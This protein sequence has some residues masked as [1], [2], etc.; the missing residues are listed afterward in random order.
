MALL[1]LF[2]PENDLALA[3]NI[4][5]YTP[6]RA[7]QRLSQAGA[8]LP[9][10][11]GSEGD[12]LLC[13]GVPARWYD[14]VCEAFGLGVGLYPHSPDGLNLEPAPWGWSLSARKTF[15]DDGLPQSSLPSDAQLEAMRALSHRRTALMLAADLDAAGI[16]GI[17]SPGVEVADPVKLADMLADQ[18]PLVLKMPWSSS[19]RGVI[20]TRST[21][22]ERALKFGIDSIRR[23]GSVI[24]EPAHDRV[25]DFAKLYECRGGKCF[26]IGT[27]VFVTDC[28]G[29]YIGN[30]LADEGER[31][32]RVAQKTDISLLDAVTEALRLSIERRIAPHYSGVLGVDMLA[33]A[34]RVLDP[35]VEVN[36]RRTMG[37]AAN[38]VAD[39]YLAQGMTGIFKVQPRKAGDLAQMLPPAIEGGRLTAGI[40][41]LVPENPYFSIFAQ[42]GDKGV[43]A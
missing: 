12:M 27:S 5:N 38:R 2:N 43:E 39:R 20:D 21:A 14:S 40:L 13:Y 18:G 33:D 1:H 29:A 37:Y 9:L 7:A 35:C 23:Q 8:A 31:R 6:P 42:V 17:A 41:H 25:I 34:R 24:V 36:L 19:G 22:K 26:E 28:R 4:A 30:L 10:W 32:R 3:A 15:L 11:Y 16:K